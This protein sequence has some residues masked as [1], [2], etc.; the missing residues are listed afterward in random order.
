MAAS[1]IIAPEE[2][3]I[4]VER[5]IRKAYEPV[6]QPKPKSPKHRLQNLLFEIFEGHEDFLGWTPD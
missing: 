4:V 5:K 3:E 6:L 1:P 2:E